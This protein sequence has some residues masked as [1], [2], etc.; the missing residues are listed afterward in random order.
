MAKQKQQQQLLLLLL[1][2]LFITTIIAISAI[3]YCSSCR[4]GYCQASAIS[5]RH[6]GPR[7]ETRTKTAT[8]TITT[9]T[10][11]I[12]TAA[13]VCFVLAARLAVVKQAS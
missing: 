9:T 8:T 1:K 6:G 7:I 12:T 3:C 13:A 11:N 10:T 4:T 5:L 2:L